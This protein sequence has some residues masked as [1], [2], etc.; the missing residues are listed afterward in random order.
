MGKIGFMFFVFWKMQIETS[1]K[2]G[3]QLKIKQKVLKELVFL[4]PHKL[5]ISDYI[6][7][8]K[9]NLIRVV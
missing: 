1:L 6:S 3:K 8:F 4:V 7:S 2:I 5:Q 9:K